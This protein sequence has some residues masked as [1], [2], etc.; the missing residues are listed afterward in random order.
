MKVKFIKQSFLLYVN[1][2][3]KSYGG[4]DYKIFTIH[5]NTGL[6][7]VVLVG[8]IEIVN[9]SIEVYPW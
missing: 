5:T 7:E 8:R 4:N 1:L 3:R 2:I 6:T 9:K